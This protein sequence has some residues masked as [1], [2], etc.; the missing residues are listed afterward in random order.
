MERI[1]E[2][3]ELKTYIK[4]KTNDYWV[5]YAVDKESRQ[6][7]DFKTGKRTKK[8]IKRVTPHVRGWQNANKLTPMAWIFT[9]LSFRKA[10]IA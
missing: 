6:V 10:Y 3:D 5:I 1:Y 8:N 7:V 4:K 2:V 9:D